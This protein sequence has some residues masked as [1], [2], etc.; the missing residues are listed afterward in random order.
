MAQ[1]GDSGGVMRDLDWHRL[2]GGLIEALDRPIFW[3]VLVRYLHDLVTY[4]TWVVLRFSRDKKP[5]VYAESPVPGGGR[6]ELFQ[7]YLNGFYMLDP[8]YID[9][10]ENPRPGLL[11]LDDVAPDH[12]EAEDYYQRYFKL[13]VTT[14]EV[15]FNL[16]MASG[17]VLIL[18]FGSRHRYTPEE[19]RI[20][21]TIEP[22]V[23]A[24][25]RQ[26]IEHDEPYE[27]G[28]APTEKL[29]E[30]PLPDS[31]SN[32]GIGTG[33]LTGRELE[34]VHLLLSGFSS[35]RIAQKLKISPETVKGHRKHIYIKLGVKTHAELFAIYLQAK[36][37]RPA[38]AATEPVTAG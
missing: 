16:P 4:D 23:L 1:A 8:F 19:M 22:W 13:N 9:C 18:S 21:S 30:S 31:I 35:K 28:G 10:I 37:P 29:A 15:H 6:D 7:D 32:A 20:F 25:M 34:I 11:R 27:N 38:V 17:D 24:L 36:T 3:N 12:F 5:V 14:D 26:R 33:R 2:I